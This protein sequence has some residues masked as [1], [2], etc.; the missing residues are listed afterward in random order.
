MK[1]SARTLQLSEANNQLLEAMSQKMGVEPD[2]VAN[3]ALYT[4]ARLN[5][6]TAPL[7]DKAPAPKAPPLPKRPLI[8]APLRAASAPPEIP[9]PEVEAAPE[10]DAEAPV[11]NAAD[12]ADAPSDEGAEEPSPDAST[13]ERKNW[14]PQSGDRP[15]LYVQ[16]GDHSPVEVDGERFVIGRSDRCNLVIKSNRVSREHAVLELRDDEFV[17]EDLG[18]ANGIWVNAKRVKSHLVSDGDE[19]S[20]GGQALRFSIA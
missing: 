8:D 6:F 13:D 18:S 1:R 3:M 15:R 7:A 2:A 19:V 12:A 14:K 17:I 9:L 4:F 5:G 11:A 10:G 20:I 16:L